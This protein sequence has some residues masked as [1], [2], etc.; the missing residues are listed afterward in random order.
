MKEK[1]INIPIY[2]WKLHIIKWDIKEILEK[3]D[4]DFPD[5]YWAITFM[6]IVDW[7]FNLYLCFSSIDVREVSHECLHWVRM[8]YEHIWAE[9]VT[10]DNDEHQCYILGWLMWECNKFLVD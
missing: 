7:V 3:Y 5:N 8:L 10:W 1:I 4:F 2:H 9:F 6:R